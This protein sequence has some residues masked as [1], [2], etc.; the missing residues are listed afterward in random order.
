MV[1]VSYNY[2]E[3]LVNILLLAPD[4]VV[5]VIYVGYCVACIAF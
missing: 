1:S 4:C 5:F 2:S 3:L